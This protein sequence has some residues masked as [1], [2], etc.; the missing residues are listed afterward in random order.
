V[1]GEGIYARAYARALLGAAQ[2][3]RDVEE[4]TRDM[5]ALEQQWLGSIEL[6]RFCRSRQ[7][8]VLGQRSSL[9]QQVW[10]D[11]LTPTTRRFLELLA[12]WGH[13]RLLPLI[14]TRFQELADRAAGRHDAEAAFACEP[15]ES[16]LAHVRQLIAAAYGPVFKLA[17]R[18]DPA[19]LA[20]VQLR[21]DDRL[22]DASLAGRLARLKHGLMKPMPLE[23]A[24]N[25][26]S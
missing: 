19:L 25:G 4:V 9:I 5:L 15:Q 13:L 23:A 2:A 18:V 14:A 24:A 26:K 22:V 21:I 11:T 6:R 3:L 17:V 1:I 8:G 12:E 7:Q 16:D 10:G 20:G